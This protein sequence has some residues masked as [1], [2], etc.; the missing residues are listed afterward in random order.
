MVTI[1]DLAKA[2]GCSSATVSKALNNYSDV[3][4]NTKERILKMAKE[5]GFTPSSQARALS[6]KKTWNI[7]VLFEDENNSGLTHY[8]FSRVLQA[9]KEQVEEKGYD[10]TFISKNFGKTRFQIPPFN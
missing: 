10:L 6:T 9:V 3:N 7:G 4:V 5:M 2:C 8:Y 1:Y